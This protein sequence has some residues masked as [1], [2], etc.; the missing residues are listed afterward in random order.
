MSQA[1][2]GVSSEQIEASRIFGRMIH[3]CA[4]RARGKSVLAAKAGLVAP[5]ESKEDAERHREEAKQLIKSIT[6]GDG[7]LLDLSILAS[8]AE[9][10]SEFVPV[11]EDSYLTSL[12]G[13]MARRP[14]VEKP[15]PLPNR[16]R[17]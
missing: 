7:H 12:V 11:G 15:G 2:A 6:A 13:K 10:A 4:V 1:Q 3:R 9:A 5:S 8:V 17:N 14:N 16:E